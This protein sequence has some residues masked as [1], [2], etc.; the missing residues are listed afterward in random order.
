MTADHNLLSK[1]PMK[2]LY[3]ERKDTK[4]A[5]HMSIR[6]QAGFPQ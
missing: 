2:N 6:P 1:P 3:S 4:V 5:E